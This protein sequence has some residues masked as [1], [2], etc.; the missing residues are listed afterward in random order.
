VPNAE[1]PR[2]AK[3]LPENLPPPTCLFFLSLSLLQNYKQSTEFSSD[4]FVPEVGINLETPSLAKS[5][6]SL[7]IMKLFL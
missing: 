4:L 1:T 5:P 3:S 2:S 7:M 6:N